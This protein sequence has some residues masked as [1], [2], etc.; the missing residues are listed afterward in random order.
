MG[1]FEPVVSVALGRNYSHRRA[2]NVYLYILRSPTKVDDR[3][4]SDTLFIGSLNFLL[5]RLI[6]DID[7]RPVSTIWVV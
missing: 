3:A 2:D 5:K 1:I 4:H 7:N 6:N